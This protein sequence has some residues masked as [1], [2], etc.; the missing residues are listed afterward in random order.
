M[1]TGSGCGRFK[2]RQLDPPVVSVVGAVEGDGAMGEVDAVGG[3]TEAG[4]RYEEKY[5]EAHGVR[6][7]KTD[8]K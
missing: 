3:V 7:G 1:R 8:L 6:H 5:E 2:V 4:R